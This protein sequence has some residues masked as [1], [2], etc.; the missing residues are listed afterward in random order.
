MIKQNDNESTYAHKIHSKDRKINF[1]SSVNDVYNKIKAFSP[2]TSAWCIIGKE[3]IKIIKCNKKHQES[4]P[5][6][7]INDKFH[8]GCKDGL[9][10]PLIVQREGKKSMNIKEFLK[11]FHFIVGQK[12]NA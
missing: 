1:S 2:T 8:L 9:I 6:I 5:S 7:I 12:I 11:G 4:L 3:S 10:K